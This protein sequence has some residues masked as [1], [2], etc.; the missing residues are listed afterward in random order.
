MTKF[1]IILLG[2]IALIAMLTVH[3]FGANTQPPIERPDIVTAP[4]V[5]VSVPVET[6]TEV[7]EAP[8]ETIPQE[9]IP[10]Y[11]RDEFWDGWMS[12]GGGCDYRQKVLSEQ[13][14]NVKFKEGSDCKVKSGVLND[15]YSGKVVNF[16]SDDYMAVQVDHVVSLEDAWYAGAWK[17]TKAERIAFAHDMDNLVATTQYMNGW[18]N[19]K[20]GAEIVICVTDPSAGCAP[21]AA[22]G[23][24]F[25]DISSFSAKYNALMMK[26]GLGEF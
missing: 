4:A 18:K 1:Q 21:D 26:Y 5:E 13:L 7:V 6:P 24:Q 10:D 11:N 8:V 17:W 15:P 9:E 22:K 20:T 19:S 3:F 23:G 2:G 25:L 14:T 16:S 12:I